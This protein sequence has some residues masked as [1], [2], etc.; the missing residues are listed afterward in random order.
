MKKNTITKAILS[1][2]ILF[3]FIYVVTVLAGVDRF[4]AESARRSAF[5]YLDEDSKEAERASE[6]HFENLYEIAAKVQAAESEQQVLEVT[7]SY[8]GSE[9]FGN[10]RY[11]SKGNVYTAAGALYAEELAENDPVNALAATNKQGCSDIFRDVSGYDC[12][13]FFVPVRGSAYIDGIL[14]IVPARNLVD[15]KNAVG[16]KASAALLIDETGHVLTA[17]YAEG[18]T[19]TVGNNFYSYIDEFVSNKSGINALGDA[20]RS[21]KKSAHSVDT[22]N[23]PYTVAMTPLAALDEKFVFV[24]LSNND[25]LVGEEMVY[26]QHILTLIILAVA[27]IVIGSVYASSYSKKMRTSIDVAS[28]TDPLIGCPNLEQFKANANKQLQERRGQFVTC[29]FEIRQFRYMSEKLED[30]EMAEIL[31]YIAKVM[32]TFCAVRETYAYMG[33]GRFAMLIV[34]SNEQ[35]VRDRVRL[36]EAMVSKHA[37]LG[38]SKAK[39]KF[40]VG[41]SIP[42][43]TKRSTVNEMLD[44]AQVA[45]DK[46]RNNINVPYE[47]Y[48]VQVSAERDSHDRIESEM[49]H[50][51]ATGEFK[52]FLQP[53]YN[54]AGDKI[55]SAEALVRWFDPKTGDYRFPGEFIGLFETNGF[56]TKLD[57]FMYV[58]TLKLLSS[59]AQRGEKVVPISVNVSLVTVNSDD[60]LDFYI[61]NKE[62]YRVGDGFIIIEFTESF[63]MGDY[64]RIHEVVSKLHQH[65]IRCSLDDF[66]TGYASLGALKNIPLDEVKL[67]RMFMKKGFDQENDEVLLETMITLIKSLG[68]KVIQ[69]GVETKEMFESAVAKGCDAI[70]GYYY[71]KAIPAEEYKLFINSNTSIKYKA[72]VK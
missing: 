72:L 60:F 51:L 55:D 14:S 33:D 24:T 45:C 52:L 39:K 16:E 15:L 20:V 8:I 69:E 36:I 19:Q 67:D 35:S 37:V 62:Q 10:L 21:G 50:A 1:L 34:Y 23:G 9:K 63:A 49:E 38:K 29:V 53:K 31:K 12:V 58:E 47:M 25:G 3:F 40:N 70:Q 56:I 5:V 64:R 44:Q 13:A 48:T 68:M 22:V 28:Y 46:A 42:S 17:A 43:G 11:Y 71:A 2:V 61:E 66:G 4:Y 54:V 57:H 30:G 65:G 26:M 6:I 27:S 32:E 18:F 59:A 7:R 41:A